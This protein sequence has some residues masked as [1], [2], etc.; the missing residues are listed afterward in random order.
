MNSVQ[1]IRPELLSLTSE[2]VAVL[3]P[4]AWVIGGSILGV[5]AC[6][7]RKPLSVGPI[8]IVAL[9]TCFLGIYSSSR[10]FGSDTLLLF[11]GMLVSDSYSNFFNIV[12]LGSAILTIITSFKYLEDEGVQ[13]PEYYG[14]ILFSVVGMMIMT[15]SLDMIVLF[16]ALE[17]MSLC[18]YTLVGFRRSDRRCNEAALKYFI[19]GGAASAVFLYGTAL[20]YGAT[21]S[22]NIKD[23]LT[24]IQSNPSASTPLFAVGCWLVIAGFL[25][26]VASV[27]FHMW[28]PDVYEG[29]PVPVTGFMTTGL[30]A[31]AFATFIRVFVSLG[32]GRGLAEVLQDHV[33]H[34]L[35]ASAV[36][37]MFIGNITALAQTNLKRMLA[38]SSI[39]HTGYLIVGML[40]GAKSEQGYAPV[41]MYLVSYA[42]MNLGAFVILTVLS[43]KGDSCLNLHDLSGV[44]RRHPLLAAAMAI[45]LFSMAGIPP[46][47]GFV[48]KYLVLYSAVQAGEIPLVVLSVLCSAIAVYY[49]LRVLVYMYMREPQSE[50]KIAG[51]PLW[52]ALALGV[53]AFLTLQLGIMPSALIEAAKQAVVSL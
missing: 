48:A 33:H 11:N 43:K 6:A 12:F 3:M 20:L 27:P 42:L 5:V 13:H 47:A 44:S 29:A 22:T 50:E 26:K 46:T 31:A 15:A 25:F 35:W 8:A 28:M 19:L 53:M 39:A 17:I 36:A 10:L 24:I 37:T 9:L 18:V 2:Q 23:I 38:Y 34:I 4:L 30:K 45:F 49:Y 32:Y 51:I 16:I 7:F 21:G 41:V 1:I 52:S 14:L 40:A